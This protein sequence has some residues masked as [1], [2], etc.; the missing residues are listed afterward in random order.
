MGP[1][2]EIFKL[3]DVASHTHFAGALAIWG[4]GAK[5]TKPCSVGGFIGH[6]G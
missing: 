4:V 5:S 6:Y 1:T 2:F 3:G